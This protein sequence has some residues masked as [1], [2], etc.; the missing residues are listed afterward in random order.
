MYEIVATILCNLDNPDH[1]QSQESPAADTRRSIRAS[2]SGMPAG[3]EVQ[4]VSAAKQPAIQAG[5]TFTE[6]NLSNKVRFEI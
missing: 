5:A 4:A 1:G 2:L 6:G 3:P